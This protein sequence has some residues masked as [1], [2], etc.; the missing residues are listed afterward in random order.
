[1][2]NLTI[3]LNEKPFETDYKKSLST[4]FL[5]LKELQMELQ[6]ESTQE[7]ADELRR[8]DLME[9]DVLH[10]IEL[11]DFNASEG[12]KFAKM[13][14]TIRRARRKIKDRLDERSKVKKLLKTYISSGFKAQLETAIVNVD[15]FEQNKQVR[16]YRLRELSELEGFNEKIQKQK[17]RLQASAS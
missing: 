17:A 2:N 16:S 6:H 10:I 11:L 8:V 13:L 15:H 14:Q 1:M 7:L 5:A 12:F 3:E 9:Q 4:I